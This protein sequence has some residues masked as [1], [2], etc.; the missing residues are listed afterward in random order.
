MLLFIW[1]CIYLIL[2]PG[3]VKIIYYVLN[4]IQTLESTKGLTCFNLLRPKLVCLLK[5]KWPFAEIQLTVSSLII[6]SD[7]YTKVIWAFSQLDQQTKEKQNDLCLVLNWGT[8]LFH[9]SRA[10]HLWKR[11]GKYGT[12]LFYYNVKE[13]V[14]LDDVLREC[15]FAQASAERLFSVIFLRTIG[16]LLDI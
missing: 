8:R 12:V 15:Q 1:R 5:L 7:F 11:Q 4:H 6:N 9:L 3:K 13:V 10:G 2:R 16:L 14:Y